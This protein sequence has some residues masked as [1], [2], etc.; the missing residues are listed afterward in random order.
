MKRLTLISCQRLIK[1][2]LL[3]LTYIDSSIMER[4]YGITSTKFL[5]YE[6]KMKKE[7][8]SMFTI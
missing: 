7:K 6:K 5:I 8:E 4:L 3:L 2:T 1:L